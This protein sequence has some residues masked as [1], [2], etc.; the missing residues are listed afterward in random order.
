MKTGMD[1]ENK[2]VICNNIVTGKTEEITFQGSIIKDIIGRAKT[3]KKIPFVGPGLVDLQVNGINGID[4]NYP[5]LTKDDVVKATHYLLSKGVTTFLPTVITNSDENICEIVHTIFEACSS[6][7][8]VSNCI[9]GIH[10]EGPFISALPGAKGA[11]DEKYIQR[12]EWELFQRYQRAAG[13]KIRLITIA[14]EWEG[15][16]SFIEKCREENILVSIGHSMATSEEIKKAVKAGAS[17]CTHLGN[18]VPLLLPRHPNVIWDLLAQDELYTCIIADGL[19][20]PDSFI[21]VVMKMKG[22]KVLIV[23]DA[24]SL[25]GMPPGEYQKHIGGSV[26]LDEEKRVSLKSTPGLLAGAAKTLLENVETMIGHDLAT[27]SEAWKMASTNVADMLA[28]N[29]AAFRHTDDRVIFELNGKEIQV[30]CVIKRD[31]IVYEQ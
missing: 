19:H 25:A 13:G 3:E 21:K 7:P 5:S 17:L 18:A 2:A 28:K 4:F 8:M 24:T 11:H 31:R 26:I 10:L 30:K 20:I 6:D 9:W 29:D 15:S 12:P 23:S 16:Y 1:N 14:P 22:E 27:I